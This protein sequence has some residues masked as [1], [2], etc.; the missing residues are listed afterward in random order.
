M[1]KKA[2]RVAGSL[3]RR[4][5]SWFPPQE[6]SRETGIIDSMADTLFVVDAEARLKKVNRA[7]LELL[8]YDEE[9]LLGKRANILF[10][11]GAAIFDGT[12]WE[13]L[14]R[15]GSL[16]N[17]EMTYRN[18]GGGWLPVSF[19]VSPMKDA[20]NRTR[21]AIFVNKDVV[22]FNAR[23]SGMRRT[24]S[25]LAGDIKKRDVALSLL[26]GEL[27][28]TRRKRDSLEREVERLSAV[29]KTKHEMDD[30][31]SKRTSELAQA[32]AEVRELRQ[33]ETSGRKDEL[34]GLFAG[35]AHQIKNP[36]TFIGMTVQHLF[37]THKSE[38]PERELFA[39]ILQKIDR[40]NETTQGLIRFARTHEIDLAPVNVEEILEKVLGLVQPRCRE[41]GIEVRR[42]YFKMLPLTADADKLEEAFFNIVDNAIRAMDE[43]GTL[44]VEIAASAGRRRG[45]G[46]MFT[47]VRISDTGKGIPEG[48]L[49]DI[50]KPF[51]S[52]HHSSG[53]GLFVVK[54]IVEAHAGEVRV[55]SEFGR[56]TSIEIALPHGA[57]A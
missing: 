11:E 19:T 44:T 48:K 27:E 26:G 13:E 49:E 56:G 25:V 32:L 35:A 33:D 3:S 40:I 45:A 53:L 7:L 1:R 46:E 9:A 16:R 15:E 52:T 21:G 38:D 50:F 39:T 29:Q 42:D 10:A 41:L 43:G 18:K 6:S 36:L 5:R 30:E 55:Y 17:V 51:F 54:R 20:L 23:I 28:D 22:R 14:A 2:D 12:L 57:S 8:D 34:E 47:I 31:V 4:L 37:K 24:Q